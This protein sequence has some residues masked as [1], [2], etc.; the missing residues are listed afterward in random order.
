MT[1]FI[2]GLSNPP[3]LALALIAL[4]EF[5]EDDQKGHPQSPNGSHSF[6]FEVSTL[7]SVPGK[8]WYAGQMKGPGTKCNHRLSPGTSEEK[9]F[10]FG[11]FESAIV[12]RVICPKDVVQLKGCNRLIM[13]WWNS[14]KCVGYAERSAPTS[15][16]ATW[17][18]SHSIW[19]YLSQKRGR[20]ILRLADT[21]WSIQAFIRHIVICIQVSWYASIW[22]LWFYRMNSAEEMA[23]MLTKKIHFLFCVSCQLKCPEIVSPTKTSLFFSFGS[24]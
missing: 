10:E 20:P 23:F 6:Y 19:K 2:L 15:A 9:P 12:V 17:T 3:S 1:A 7:W 24:H 18:C 5:S 8:K 21:N 14:I 4:G 22:K 16:Q 13:Y 11:I